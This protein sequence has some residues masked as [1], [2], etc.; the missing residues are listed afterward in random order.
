MPQPCL[1]Q[2][3]FQNC[4]NAD[5]AER[6]TTGNIVVRWNGRKV[7]R[8]K[9][10][11]AKRENQM[12]IMKTSLLV[13]AFS[14]ALFI[15]G[16]QAAPAAAPVAGPAGP[17]G[18]TGATGATGDPGQDATRRTEEERRAEEARR[19][20]DQRITDARARDSHDT[21]CPGGEHVFTAPDGRKS[22]VRD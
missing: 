5:S 13:G 9:S 10:S 14:L 1:A 15:A 3:R 7:A 8:F 6:G 22:C 16:C 20:E 19:A 17:Q 21:G 11:G 4:A 2:N 18:S 12:K